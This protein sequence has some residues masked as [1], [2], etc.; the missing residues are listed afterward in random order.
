M[1]TVIWH[2]ISD[3]ADCVFP[4]QTPLAGPLRGTKCHFNA[5]DTQ[6]FIHLAHKNTGAV[7]QK[8]N[9]YLHDIKH[10]MLNNSS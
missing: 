3:G 8:L 10:W 5:G 9:Q 1:Q 2:A 4:V 7:F 6:L